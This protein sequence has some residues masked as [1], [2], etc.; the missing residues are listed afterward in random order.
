MRVV[1]DEN[2]Y[3]GGSDR[4]EYRKSDEFIVAKKDV[5]ASGA[6]GLGW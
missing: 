5:K 2:P 4:M 6:K 3:K 1:R